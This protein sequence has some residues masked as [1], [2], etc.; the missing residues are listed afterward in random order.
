MVAPTGKTVVVSGGTDGMGRAVALDRLR[1]G[2][3]VVVLGSNEAK[4]RTL[5]E[6]AGADASRLRFLRADLS[7]I[8][9]NERVIANIAD[10]HR[11]VDA[12]VL[13]ANR[14]SPRR[15]ETAEG[16]EFVFALY[17]LSRYLLSYG[18]RPQFEQAEAPVIVSIAGVGLTAGSIDFSDLQQT[19]KYNAI[20]A[21]LQA[22]RA[23][24]LLGVAFA[25]Q[26]ESRARF[27]MYHPGF[28][29]SGDVSVLG[30][31]TRTA[32][33]VLAMVGARSVDKAIAPV[34]GFLDEPPQAP[35]TAR[36]RHKTVPSSL[37][38]LDP[39]RARRLA[40]HTEALL[41]RVRGSGEA[42]S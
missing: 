38:T 5:Q 4:G 6:T 36:D 9:E 30:P 17:Y 26:A 8:A 33:R 24:D 11:R 20:K 10:H 19:S 15:Q 29:R 40:A 39:E 14:Q 13:C 23:N 28:T 7:L 12:L 27:V 22:G 35:L 3:T 41:G 34:L 37:P 32:I 1:R 16:L 42:L 25:E 18:L 2:D 31:V 21:Q